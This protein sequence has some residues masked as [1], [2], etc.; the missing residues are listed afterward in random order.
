MLIKFLYC[1]FFRP[2]RR[3]R[4][5]PPLRGG[6]RPPYRPKHGGQPQYR[7]RYPPPPP[8]PHQQRYQHPPP[9]HWNS[10]WRQPTP[11]PY[12]NTPPPSYHPQAARDQAAESYAHLYRGGWI[13]DNWNQQQQYQD[14]RDIAI[15]LS[16]SVL[17]LQK[18]FIESQNAQKV[19]SKRK[20]ADNSSGS[21][22]GPSGHAAGHQ[23]TAGPSGHAGKK[24]KMSAAGP[25]RHAAGNNSSSDKSPAGSS[26]QAGEKSKSSSENSMDTSEKSNNP[27]PP[28]K[29][30][31][32]C[33][34]KNQR[35][36]RRLQRR[37]EEQ[38][39][40]AREEMQQAAPAQ[41]PA[42]HPS[43]PQAGQEGQCTTSQASSRPTSQM[44]NDSGLE[45]DL[46]A[47]KT[48]H[49]RLGVELKDRLGKL[50]ETFE[51]DDT[52]MNDNLQ[53]GQNNSVFS[54]PPKSKFEKQMESYDKN[55]HADESDMTEKQDSQSTHTASDGGEGST[56]NGCANSTPKG[57]NEGT[58]DTNPSEKL[59]QR[60]LIKKAII[61][62]I[63]NKTDPKTDKEIDKTDNEKDKDKK[64]EQEKDKNISKKPKRITRKAKKE[65][66]NGHMTSKNDKKKNKASTSKSKPGISTTTTQNT[67]DSEAQSTNKD[68]VES[69]VSDD[70]LVLTDKDVKS[71]QKGKEGIDNETDLDSYTDNNS[72][73]K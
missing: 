16:N 46:N 14:L 8:P 57:G 28:E 65:S 12:Y 66:K 63:Q 56:T 1:T 43:H 41:Q 42:D 44:S 4:F 21:A 9:Q 32:K 7:G 6:Q 33:Y 47:S 18:A 48:I 45:V 73:L 39:A 22:A 3:P 49:D 15:N 20:H 50:R 69:V 17:E 2:A 36:K 61:E 30:K 64:I 54:P 5:D 67:E 25:S 23:S 35:N 51:D 29:K 40:A 53:E 71:L 11:P 27:P 26:E 58:S 38:Q 72:F 31:G 13:T 62:K 37:F 24:K 34:A 70:C 52:N 55:Y 59:S 19:G 10:G 68:D 60:S